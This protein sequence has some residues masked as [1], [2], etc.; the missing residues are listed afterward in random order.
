MPTTVRPP[1]EPVEGGSAN[2]Y[3]YTGGDPVNGQDLNGLRGTKALPELDGECLGGNETQLNTDTCRRYQQAKVTGDSDLYYYGR[4]LPVRH[5]FNQAISGFCPSFVRTGASFV[6]YGD[7]A[8]A[9]NQ[10]A[11]GNRDQAARTG[12][13]AAAATG[14]LSTFSLATGKAAS[15][16]VR[17]VG[18][19]G[20]LPAGAAATAV[21]GV[22]T[23][24]S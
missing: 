20:S 10:L 17:S 11:K 18:K 1:V 5:D 16:A 15:L 21:D 3:D 9:G 2:D 23:A 22:C 19:I 24:A 14:T 7:F 6:G 4:I 13:R 12:G 8:R